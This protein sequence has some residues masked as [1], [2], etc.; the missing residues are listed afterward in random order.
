MAKKKKEDGDNRYSKANTLI[1]FCKEFCPPLENSLVAALLSS[2]TDKSTRSELKVI[3]DTLKT[4][5]SSTDPKYVVSSDDE[6]DQWSDED[7][8]D[9]GEQ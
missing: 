9:D 3:R 6:E 7:S 4:L 5:A 1:R 2:Y 8:E